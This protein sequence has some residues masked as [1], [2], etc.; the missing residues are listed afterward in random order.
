[1]CFDLI[2][3]CCR[4]I[5]LFP[6]GKNS[7]VNQLH[8]YLE[9]I[10]TANMSEGWKRDAKFKFAVFNQV[11][12]NSTITEGFFSP[13]PPSCKMIKCMFDIIMATLESW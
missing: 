7:A 8:I 5:L 10:K 11:E 13:L 12:D 2:W 6:K 4:R 3:F 9:A 1:M